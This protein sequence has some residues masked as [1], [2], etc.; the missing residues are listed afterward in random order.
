[1]HDLVVKGL[2]EVEDL[3]GK[4]AKTGSEGV[5]LYEHGKK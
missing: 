3:C 5:H 4:R 1:M 2:V